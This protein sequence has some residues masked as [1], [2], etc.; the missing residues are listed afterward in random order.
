MYEARKEIL[1]KSAVQ[2]KLIKNFEPFELLP[3]KNKRFFQYYKSAGNI[4]IEAPY[5]KSPGKERYTREMAIEIG[6][7]LGAHVIIGKVSSRENRYL[8][9]TSSD[10]R[11]ILNE[12]HNLISEFSNGHM[13]H[14]ILRG[15]SNER[16]NT[17]IDIS[18]KFG[19]SCQGY[20]IEKVKYLFDSFKNEYGYKW[21]ITENQIFNGG[22]N[23]LIY[24]RDGWRSLG[25]R[26]FGQN[27]NVMEIRLRKELREYEFDNL[28][29]IIKNFLI[30]IAY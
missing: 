24:L 30:E 9:S 19:R 4:I 14:I 23:A 27:Y 26:G 1:P 21:K 6:F 18:T 5:S 20:Y 13:L 22:S 3:L 12:Y 10:C 16:Y 25:L 11:E 29:D 8:H 28:V 17:D 15:F 2:R 7:N